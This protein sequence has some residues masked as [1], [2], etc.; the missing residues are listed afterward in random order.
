MATKTVVGVTKSNSGASSVPLWKIDWELTTDANEY[1][2]AGGP[3]PGSLTT[4]VTLTLSNEIYDQEYRKIMKIGSMEIDKYPWYTEELF[5]SVGNVNLVEETITETTELDTRYEGRTTFRNLDN[6]TPDAKKGFGEYNKAKEE[7]KTE[8]II[9]TTSVMNDVSL[10]SDTDELTFANETIAKHIAK[11]HNTFGAPFTYIDST[12][13]CYYSTELDIP[14]VGRS[15]LSTIY[16]NPAVFSICPGKVTYMPG[17][18]KGNRRKEILNTIKKYGNNLSKYGAGEDYEEGINGAFGEALYEFSCDYSDYV[19]RLNGLA[20]TASIMLGIGDKDM[21]YG[22][23]G[24]KYK[25]FDYGYYTTANR[26]NQSSSS[27]SKGTIF[28]QFFWQVKENFEAMW[29]DDQYIHYFLS[30]EGTTMSEE[31]SIDVVPSP[32]KDM[33]GGTGIED[34]VR[35]LHFMLGGSMEGDGPISKITEDLE[36]LT[37]EIGATGNDSIVGSLIGAVGAIASGGKLIVPDMI[38]GASWGQSTSCT[39]YFRSLTGDPEDVFLRVM[40][41]TLSILNF[42]LPKQLSNNMY[43]YPYV[44]KTYQRGKFNADLAVL[45]GVQIERGGNDD[46]Q[47]T[48]NGLPTDI[49][50]SFN[51]RPLHQSLMAGNGRNPFVF[52]ENGPMMEYLGNLCG[53]DLNVSQVSMKVDLINNLLGNFFTDTPTSVGRGFASGIKDT[54]SGIFTF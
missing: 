42:A 10:G 13:I 32:L 49:K 40:L 15:Q 27:Q 19:N 46:I 8:P 26:G 2:Q 35:S 33:I 12:D 1:V 38:G 45:E 24:E 54:L 51:I 34:T 39:L 43:G 21:P 14:R 7:K 6:K 11:Y 37:N 52:M 3:G 22:K 50:V 20:R 25:N 44:V 23:N 47:W 36:K 30:N 9:A 28:D 16:S 4:N 41:P 17:F 5:I 29:D 48:E 53:I 31:A 18:G